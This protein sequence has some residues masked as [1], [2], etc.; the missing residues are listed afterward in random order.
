MSKLFT[1]A[2]PSDSS[3]TMVWTLG[4]SRAAF[5]AHCTASCMIP[6]EREKLAVFGRLQGSNPYRLMDV[7]M[8]H[9]SASDAAAVF[10]N[11]VFA[12]AG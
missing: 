3:S 5:P 10:A 6:D 9:V 7:P 8:T 1:R 11:Q 4:L 12:S 2:S